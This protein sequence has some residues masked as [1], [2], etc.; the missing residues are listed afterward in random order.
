MTLVD[1]IKRGFLSVAADIKDLYARD[2]PADFLDQDGTV[3]TKY[4]K[5]GKLSETQFQQQVPGVSDIEVNPVWFYD[6]VKQ[7]GIAEGW[8]VGGA[9]LGAPELSVVSSTS[10]ANTLSWIQVAE[11]TLYVLQRSVNGA[12]VTIYSGSLLTFTDS[13][14]SASTVFQ[15]RLFCSAAGYVNSDY[16]TQSATTAE[17]APSDNN[18]EGFA[19]MDLTL[20]NVEGHEII[21]SPSEVFSAGDLYADNPAA[22]GKG[23]VVGSVI[24]FKYGTK[25]VLMG[26]AEGADDINKEP[27]VY[28]KAD[29]LV[30]NTGT[31]QTGDTMAAVQP[32]EG[33]FILLTCVSK[34]KY[35]VSYKKVDGTVVA[36]T[37][38]TMSYDLLGTNPYVKF[39]LSESA[40]VYYPQGKNLTTWIAA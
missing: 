1:W 30:I 33:D 20:L 24:A 17:A 38:L 2:V 10:S 27:R 18:M 34:T 11:A 29:G 19:G 7:V 39:K 23:M 16:A 13:G 36:V 5:P 40:K 26:L 9:K 32:T 21:E 14:L 4:M 22:P 31:N 25:D 35:D 3:S 12:W 28:I 15:Y 37:T 6:A 8:N